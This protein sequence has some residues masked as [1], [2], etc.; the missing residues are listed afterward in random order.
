MNN[1]E[2]STLQ[3]YF[4]IQQQLTSG[5]RTSI[6]SVT[7]NVFHFLNASKLQLDLSC[8]LQSD[9]KPCM[10]V[11]HFLVHVTDFTTEQQTQPTEQSLQITG[12]NS[13]FTYHSSWTMR[14][15]V[16]TL[17]QRQRLMLQNIFLLTNS[18]RSKRFGPKAQKL[19]LAEQQLPH[20]PL[21]PLHNIRQELI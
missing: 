20:N 2:S 14:L 8:V 21:Q 15:P 11:Y 7:S 12:G 6:I 4:I 17:R 1:Q 5:N 19:H 3:M 10:S 13:I 18:S 9:R 16:L